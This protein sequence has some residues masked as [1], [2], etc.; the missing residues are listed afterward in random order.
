VIALIVATRPQPKADAD[1]LAT[2]DQID[3]AVMPVRRET[4]ALSAS[5]QGTVSPKREIDLVSQVSGKINWVAP[6]IDDGAFF[7]AGAAL[8]RID[9]RDYE[10]ALSTASARVASAQRIMAEEEGRALQAKREWRD[11]GSDSANELFLRR[12][13]LAAARSELDAAKAEMEIAR[14]NVERTAIAAPFDGRISKLQVDVGQYVTVGTPLAAIYDT[15]AA[16]VRIPLTD[17]QLATL[18][19]PLGRAS[20]SGPAVTIVATVGG[21][22]HQ[23]KGA[24]T[25]TDASVDTQSRMYYAIAEVSN[26]FGTEEQAAPVPLM[27]GLFVTAEIEGR[28]LQDVI[29][30]PRE[31]L[32]RRHLV[33]V[34]D[35][36]NRVRFEEADVL[37]KSE[38]HVWLRTDVPDGTPI[39][40]NKHA[41]LP[42][43]TQVTPVPVPA[44]T[45]LA[46]G[47]DE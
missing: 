3:V 37:A 40:L 11:L 30:L 33:Y 45:D 21:R 42:E 26:P 41:L 29:V 16:E 1:A 27:P 43:G 13:Q 8:I 24:V 28:Q 17:K 34:L 4:V 10:A 35:D 23:W 31:A 14:V 44:E 18:Q 2:V 47:G 7:K 12:P 9:P 38:T 19:L 46:G 15:S 22:Q 32:V 25:R 5:G 36:D 20:G 6:G 39:V